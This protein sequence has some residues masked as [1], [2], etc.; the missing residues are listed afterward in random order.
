MGDGVLDRATISLWVKSMPCFLGRRGKGKPLESTLRSEL[1][2]DK[3]ERKNRVECYQSHTEVDLSKP[4][5]KQRN[6]KTKTVATR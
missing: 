3:L 6:G 4:K 1:P 2:L 5:R